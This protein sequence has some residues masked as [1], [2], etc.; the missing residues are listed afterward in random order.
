MVMGRFPSP[1][2]LP[3]FRPVRTEVVETDREILSKAEYEKRFREEMEELGYNKELIEMGVK[4]AK[5][6]MMTPAQA[7]EI[8]RN[9]IK[10]TA[11]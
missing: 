5:G 9:Y 7:F 10:E 11:K 1:P 6:H 3:T 2:G 8:G 4:V